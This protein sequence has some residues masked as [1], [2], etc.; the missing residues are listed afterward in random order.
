M[1]EIVQFWGALE[2]RRAYAELIDDSEFLAR[3][4][5][6]PL[7]ADSCDLLAKS[8]G[9]DPLQFVPDEHNLIL[10]DPELLFPGLACPEQSSQAL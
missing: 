1:R 6:P 10:N 7:K 5:N 2:T 3:P 8:A 9:V 4:S